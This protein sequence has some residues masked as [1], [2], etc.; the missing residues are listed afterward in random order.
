RVLAP[1]PGERGEPAQTRHDQIEE[2]AVNRSRPKNVERFGAVQGDERGIAA[3]ANRFR[4]HF[5]HGRVIVHHEDSHDR[6][7]PEYP[8]PS[9]PSSRSVLSATWPV[10]P[11]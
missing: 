10:A 1:D 6:P 7:R 11:L 9:P 3:R 8:N 5:G 4:D 2:Y